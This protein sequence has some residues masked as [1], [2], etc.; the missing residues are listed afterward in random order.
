MP[1]YLHLTPIQKIIANSF[2]PL[3][4]LLIRLQTVGHAP[5]TPQTI[6]ATVNLWLA[7][8]IIILCWRPKTKQFIWLPATV[9]IVFF[10][11]NWPTPV[12][13][14]QEL[15]REEM[16]PIVAY[17]NQQIMPDDPV[18]VYYGA[19]PAYRVYNQNEKTR[20]YMAAGFAVGRKRVK[21]PKS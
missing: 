17:L 16:K 3:N 15:P 9:L 11:P 2:R 10:L 6:I 19:V 8:G 18:Y 21:L 4:P 13:P 1:P 7:S 12:N 14:W 20:L 5:E